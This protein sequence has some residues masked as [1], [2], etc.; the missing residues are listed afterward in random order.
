MHRYKDNNGC[1]IYTYKSKQRVRWEHYYY[2]YFI[3]FGGA[4]WKMKN[5]QKSVSGKNR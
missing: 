5:M 1:L 2:Y 3:I 4:V